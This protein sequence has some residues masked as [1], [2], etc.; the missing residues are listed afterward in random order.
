[1]V[2]FDCSGEH[3]WVSVPESLEVTD[4][5]ET[6]IVTVNDLVVESYNCAKEKGWHSPTKTFGEEIALVH[7]E[8]SEALEEFRKGYSPDL[9]Y[10]SGENGDKPEG[11]PVELADAVI[12]VFDMCGKYGIDIETAIITKQEYNRTRPERH[13]GKVL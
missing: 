10:Y 1:M 11:I 5:V 9:M 7:S 2:N 4:F 6:E 8:L 3:P 13:G 12:R